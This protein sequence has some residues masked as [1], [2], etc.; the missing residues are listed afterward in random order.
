MPPSSSPLNPIEQIW[1]VFKHRIRRSFLAPGGQSCTDAELV[2]LCD[3]I[4]CRIGQREVQAAF[5]HM[6]T[7]YLKTMKEQQPVPSSTWDLGWLR[8]NEWADAPRTGSFFSSGVFSK[9]F[10]HQPSFWPF[11]AFLGRHSSARPMMIRM[12]KL[13]MDSGSSARG[14]SISWIIWVIVIIAGLLGRS[15]NFRFFGNF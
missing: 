9:I 8:L 3:F 13:T 2:D 11:A 5:E 15:Q 12:Q 10:C 7:I 6:R 4:L 1:S 14:L